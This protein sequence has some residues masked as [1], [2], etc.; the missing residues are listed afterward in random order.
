MEWRALKPC[1]AVVPDAPRPHSLA[2]TGAGLLCPH[3]PALCHEEDFFPIPNLLG[4]LSEVFHLLLFLEK[5][6]YILSSRIIKNISHFS[7][8]LRKHL[9]HRLAHL[10]HEG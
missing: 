8:F 3:E 6:Y 5:S 9:A 4:K 1:Y 7:L 2:Y 10:L